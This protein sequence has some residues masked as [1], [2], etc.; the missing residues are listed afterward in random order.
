[1]AENEMVGWHHQ[2]HGHE[3]EQTL[4][5]SEGQES[6]VCCSPWGPKEWN[7][8]EQLNSKMLHRCLRSNGDRVAGASFSPFLLPRSLSHTTVNVCYSPSLSSVLYG[9]PGH[10]CLH[11]SHMVDMVFALQ[12]RKRRKFM[13]LSEGTEKSVTIPCLLRSHCEMWENQR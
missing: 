1:M 6:L 7:M 12:M 10:L 2:L 4:G 11:Q 3:F 8:T 13:S 9:E 5:D